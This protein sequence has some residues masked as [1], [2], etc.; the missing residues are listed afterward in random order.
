M[1]WR[2]SI[3][4]LNQRNPLRPAQLTPNLTTLFRIWLFFYHAVVYADVF[5]T[6]ITIVLTTC[7]PLY[8]KLHFQN[9]P[10][11]R[12]SKRRSSPNLQL[13]IN[14]IYFLLIKGEEQIT[15]VKITTHWLLRW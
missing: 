11:K 3:D 15:L 14:Y 2:V 7:S 5:N 8:I 9:K 13:C 1:V 6:V 4:A 10:T 12:I